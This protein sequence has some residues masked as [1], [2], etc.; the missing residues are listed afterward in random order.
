MLK[1]LIIAAVIACSAC[2]PAQDAHADTVVVEVTA[3]VAPPAPVVETVVVR[4]GYVWTNGYWHW[5]VTRWVW[6]R[7][8]HVRVVPG[9]R[10]E[11]PHY[12]L[13]GRAWVFHRGRWVR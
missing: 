5:T 12:V 13:R 1:K 10:W 2:V 11:H 3:P 9:Y 4:P 6:V 8:Y 7:G